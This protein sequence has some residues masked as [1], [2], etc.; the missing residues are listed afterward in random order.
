MLPDINDFI[1]NRIIPIATVVNSFKEINCESYVIRKIMYSS[2]FIILF[3][4]YR[5]KY[6]SFQTLIRENLNDRQKE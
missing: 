5:K 1:I 6:N 3:N 4:G 2:S